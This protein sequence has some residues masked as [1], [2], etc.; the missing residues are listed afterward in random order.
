MYG[1]LY[2]IVVAFLSGVVAVFSKATVTAVSL[3]STV[4]VRPIVFVTI[5]IGYVHYHRWVRFEQ[6]QPTF[7]ATIDG[8]EMGDDVVSVRFADSLYEESR[9]VPIQRL[10]VVV[11]VLVGDYAPQRTGGLPQGD[12]H[13]TRRRRG[14]VPV[15]LM[16]TICSGRRSVRH[17]HRG[18]CID[19][20]PSPSDSRGPT[21]THASSK[22]VRESPP[23]SSAWRRSERRRFSQPH[24]GTR[25][26]PSAV[27]SDER[28]CV[29]RFPQMLGIN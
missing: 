6:G 21:D 8:V 23:F 25:S 22:S 5:V 29:H 26:L 17:C 14:L 10:S 15:S 28:L 11:T 7:Y 19:C 18:S 4:L 13:R 9:I 24:R 12:L 2:V 1:I 20:R 27:R 3:W 16:A